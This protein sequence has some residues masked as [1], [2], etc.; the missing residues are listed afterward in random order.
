MD[1][2]QYIEPIFPGSWGNNQLFYSIVIEGLLVA[3][4]EG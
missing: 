3:I 2:R 1:I 4:N